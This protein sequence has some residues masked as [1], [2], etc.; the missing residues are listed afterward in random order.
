MSSTSSVA[1]P[2]SGGEITALAGQH[3]LS[4]QPGSVRLNEAGLDYLVAYAVATDGQDWVLRIPRRNDMSE[5]IRTEA[6]V[7]E[8]VG[9][10]LQDVAVPQWQNVADDLIAYPLLP[11]SPALTIDDGVPTFHVDVASTVYAAEL[12]RLLAAVH[13]I[14]A[15]AFQGAGL[16]PVSIAEVREQ[17]RSDLAKVAAAF[18]VAAH[19]RRR[20]EAWLEDD[21]Y[22]P[23]WTTFTHGEPYHAHV[24]VD[25][26]QQITGVLDWT[27]AAIGDPATDLAFQYMTAP[28]EVFEVTV[29]HYAEAG[30]RTWPRLA[31]HCGELMSFWPVNYGKYA[32]LTGNPE[33]A[34]AARAQL[35]PPQDA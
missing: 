20:W 4:I 31:D 13:A 23:T 3:G 34:E 2:R 22:W 30:G 21:S 18:P 14:P 7:L 12:G 27:T 33:H 26:D 32:L 19:L 25:A 9:R 28:V 17:R 29:R 6:A 1:V 10:H 11:G 16:A 24:L 8:V 5:S 35:D 15:D